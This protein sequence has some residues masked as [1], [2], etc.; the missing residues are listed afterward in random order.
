MEYN[1]TNRGKIL[2]NLIVICSFRRL[3]KLRITFKKIIIQC[4][5]YF[6]KQLGINALP[7]EYFVDIE[8]CTIH[9]LRQPRCLTTLLVELGLYQFPY[10]KLFRH[11]VALRIWQ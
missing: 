6:N 9:L 1:S 4:V 3:K 8:S 11:P 7:L 2:H 10:V 5:G